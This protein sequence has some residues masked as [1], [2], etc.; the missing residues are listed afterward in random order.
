MSYE[1]TNPRSSRL[2]W[3]LLGCGCTLL[4]V[5]LLA[6]ASLWTLGN[7]IFNGP[8]ESAR[9]A[10]AL[11]MLDSGSTA[12]IPGLFLDDEQLS[13]LKAEA[14]TLKPEDPTKDP[15]ITVLPA[16][17]A[18]DIWA[19]HPDGIRIE[20]LTRRTFTAHVMLVRDPSA[21]YLATSTDSFSLD[22]PGTRLLNQMK[23]EGAIAAINAGAFNDD[24]TAGVHV[25]SLPIGLVVSEGRILWDDGRS[26]FGFMGMTEDDRLYVADTIT[27]ATAKQ[28]K[29]RDG[30]CFGPILVKDGQINERVFSMVDNIN[31]RSA[32]GQRADG[33]M[34]FVCIDGRQAGSIGAE[35]DDL[36]QLMLDLGAV[37]AC[38]LDGGA[39]TVM[40]Y[41]D[42]YGLYGTPGEIVMCNSYSLLQAMPRRMPTFFMVRPA[43]QED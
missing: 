28:M 33:T 11:S 8:S 26:Y 23:T 32:I 42:T 29:I 10:L 12:W 6:A 17:E 18:E 39:S 13:Q 9:D 5:L 38:A 15:S 4:T 34:I 21:V 40:G 41:K 36:P 14:P 19:D 20:T 43:E 22:I 16:P 2:R 7:W 35:Y 3:I 30:C 25:G 1:Q 27:A 24:G 37:N 31:S